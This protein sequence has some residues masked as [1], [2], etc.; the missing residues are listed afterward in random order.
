MPKSLGV[1][2]KYICDCDGGS[3]KCLK[4]PR[5]YSTDLP[6]SKCFYFRQAAADVTVEDKKRL[7]DTCV[8]DVEDHMYCILNK[9]AVM[10]CAI[11][12]KPKPAVEDKM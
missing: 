2:V 8:A 10:P 9:H 3:Y 4:N 1:C 5:P 7:C 6:N 11:M 12:H